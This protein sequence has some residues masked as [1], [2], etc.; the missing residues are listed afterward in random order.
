MNYRIVYK[1][2]YLSHHGTKGQ[3]WGVRNGPPYPLSK[4]TKDRIK[5]K[6]S[7]NIVDSIIKEALDSGIVVDKLNKESQQRHLLGKH[8]IEGK[9]YLDISYKKAEEIYEKY[10]GTGQ[11]IVD[12]NGNWTHHEQVN[13]P[14]NVAVYVDPET[15]KKTRSNIIKITY[16][17]TG[18]HMMSAN[19]GK[20]K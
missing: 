8:Y 3:K 4:E 10:R 9:S 15:G 18:S 11:A 14:Y 12:K 1:N 13:I 2:Y 17:K 19:T 7:A 5:N 16:S 20:K 6:E